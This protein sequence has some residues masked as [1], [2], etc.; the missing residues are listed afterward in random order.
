MKKEEVPKEA[1]ILDDFLGMNEEP[2]Q[3]A[4]ITESLDFLNDITMPVTEEQHS[5]EEEQEDE[6]PEPAQ[7]AADPFD[8]LNF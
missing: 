5:E 1:D 4:Q 6:E 3:P 7:P 2:T 8:F